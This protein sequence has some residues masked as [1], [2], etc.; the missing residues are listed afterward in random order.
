MTHPIAS[1]RL[2]QTPLAAAV[3]SLLVACTPPVAAADVARTLLRAD[4]AHRLFAQ[5]A[6]ARAAAAEDAAATLV[7]T[8]CNDDGPGSL[9]VAVAAAASG[10]TIDLSG[11]SCATITLQTGAIAVPLDDLTLVG[12]GR[13]ALAIDG[14]QL[15]RVFFHPHGGTLTLR[16]VEVRNGSNRASGFDLAGG[17]CIASAGYVV[18]DDASVS[19]CY[20]GGE[21]AYGGAIYA[22]S[23][24][25]IDSVLSGN[26]GMGVHPDA[27]TAAFGGGAFVY[28]MELRRSTVSGNATVHEVAPGRTSYDIGAGIITVRGGTI[29]DS[30]IDSNVSAGRGGG[31][32]SFNPVAISNSTFSGNV[33]QTEIGGALFLRRPATALIVNSTFSANRAGGAGGA[34][35]FGAAAELESSIVFG[36][37]ASD[38]ANLYSP[39]AAILAGA[40]NLIGSSSPALTLPTDTLAVAPRLGALADNGGPTRTH[41]L[42][43]GSPAVDAGSNLAALAFDQRGAGFTRVY[44]AAA[45]IG[46][47]EQQALPAPAVALPVPTLSAWM[48]GLLGIAIGVLGGLGRRSR[49][50]R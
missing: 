24:T 13:D 48:V 10:D 33:A 43:R 29:A 38:G 3:V 2:R 16:G 50:S 5:L 35:W 40:N 41:A 36:N 44:G 49:A 19:H 32:A 14:N 11:L 27:G 15:D 7:V 46:A 25:M 1:R 4:P 21:G 28:T 42:E 6:P 8:N 45:D 18:L 34:I 30:T 37:A 20:A 26:I 47:F 12:R 23:L 39:V 9:R 22:Y 31:I 17:G